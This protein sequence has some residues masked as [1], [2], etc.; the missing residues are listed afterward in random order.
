MTDTLKTRYT[1]AY[2]TISKSRVGALLDRASATDLPIRSWEKMAAIVIIAA[3]ALWSIRHTQNWWFVADFWE[4]SERDGFGGWFET[5]GGHLNI[6]NVAI[7]KLIKFDGFNY[8][9]LWGTLKVVA[10]SVMCGVVWWTLRQVGARPLVALALLVCVATFW[11]NLMVSIA[12]I[13]IPI[14]LAG[15][16]L[17]SLFASTNQRWKLAGTVFATSISGSTA[18]LGTAALIAVLAR[19]RATWGLLPW[20]VTPMIPYGLWYLQ[21]EAPKRPRSWPG[22]V[23]SLRSLWAIADSAFAVYFRD[24][25]VPPLLLSV[26]LV[27]VLA[28]Q[29][30][31]VA[32]GRSTGLQEEVF[33]VCT[34]LFLLA[35]FWDRVLTGG[36][37]GATRY[38]L[39]FVF[40][41]AGA[42]APGLQLTGRRRL[43][44][45]ALLLGVA[46][47][48][49]LQLDA[50][51]RSYA[52][53]GDRGTRTHLGVTGAVHLLGNG[54]DHLLIQPFLPHAQGGGQLNVV[55]LVKLAS[56]SWN[57]TPPSTEKLDEIQ[58]ELLT[59]VRP[60]A[61]M[62]DDCSPLADGATINEAVSV[63][64]AAD[65][66][67][68]LQVIWSGSDF[69][70]PTVET[71]AS[72]QP[73][74]SA[75]RLK[76]SARNT[77]NV[78]PAEGFEYCIVDSTELK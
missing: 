21:A 72:V 52:V 18:I 30:G 44:E 54:H 16:C 73:G 9:P 10:W 74:V 33:T 41:L 5:H 11:Y 27:A 45:V 14:S 38:G 7:V 75:I 63:V 57:P 53:G 65:T 12:L 62:P 66:K 56:S 55:D 39:F 25:P 4:F 28:R 6:Y 42:I 1:T 17:M 2:P 31:R 34:G 61:A 43:V 26:V 51:A 50:R 8:W 3:E 24:I 32:L 49:A 60:L 71:V 67:T 59:D 36:P 58:A 20:C 22:V 46:T 37:T 76:G 68:D 69:S 77:A 13:N 70:E 15:I 19:R 47:I 78:V 35:I 64:V 29:I 48:T 23:E 40:F